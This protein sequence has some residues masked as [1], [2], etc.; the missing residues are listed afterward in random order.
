VRLS[1]LQHAVTHEHAVHLMDLLF[2]R[3]GLGW[4]HRFSDEEIERAA[5]VL[6]T[7][8][9]L[10]PDEKRREIERFKHD[11]ERLFGPR[12]RQTG[13]AMERA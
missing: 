4:R 3:T 1:D 6:A 9:R 5:S 2:R 8:R 10:S 12:V 13:T 11:Y 7:E